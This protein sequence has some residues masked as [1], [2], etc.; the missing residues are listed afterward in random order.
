MTINVNNKNKVR[1]AILYKDLSFKLQGIFF[2]MRNELGS[3]YKEKIYQKA[4]ENYLKKVGLS[5]KKE[6]PIKVYSSTGEFLGLYRPDFVVEDKIIV[7]VKAKRFLSKQEVSIVYDYLRN[8][9]YEV[10]YL[11]NFGSK[12]LYVKR[13]IFTNDLKKWTKN[14]REK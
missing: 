11:V 5:F 4:F 2:E 1:R 7:E 13:L 14:T 10:A 6:F 12:K 9:E 8:S 3:G